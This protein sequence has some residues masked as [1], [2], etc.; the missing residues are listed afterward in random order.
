MLNIAER[1]LADRSL[2]GEGSVITTEV[3]LRLAAAAAAGVL[4]APG[5]RASLVFCEEAYDA[6]HACAPKRALIQTRTILQAREAA[7]WTH[8]RS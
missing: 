4:A 8:C 3:V 5:G 1:E 6:A 2:D 7:K